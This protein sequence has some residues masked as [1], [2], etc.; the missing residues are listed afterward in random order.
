MPRMG[1]GSA[2]ALRYS[3]SDGTGA[4][5]HTR[6][7]TATYRD[8]IGV[9]Q[10]AGVNVLRDSHYARNPATGLYE[11]SALIELAGANIVLQSENFGVTWG[12]NGTPT[13]VA[14]AHTASGV[15]LDLITDDDGAVSEGYEQPI[16][17]TGDAV[18]AVSIFV[19]EGTIASLVIRIRDTTAAVNRL[20]GTMTWV[21]GVPSLAMT[22][23]TYLGA[24]AYADGVYRL[25]FATSTVTAA[26]THFVQ[27]FLGGAGGLTGTIYMGGVQIEN[28]PF[29]TSY[30]PTTVAVA[31][32]AVD[33]WSL[34]FTMT[35]QESTWYV[36]FIERGT[37]QISSARLFQLSQSG[38]DANAFTVRDNGAGRYYARLTDGT[39]ATLSDS[40]MAVAPLFGDLVELR[41][42]ISPAGVVQLHQSVNNGAEASGVAGSAAGFPSQWGGGTATLWLGSRGGAGAGAAEFYGVKVA[43]GTRT[44]AEMRAA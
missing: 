15:S 37:L 16:V 27:V 40:A 13:R 5:T 2:L 10:S 6:A 39:P 36:K 24:I 4:S 17:F 38:A 11:R 34:L 12:L 29:P 25:L 32:R 7:G 35:P 23:G 19:K 21:S 9:Q 8:S 26:N 30:K 31:P 33:V 3:P 18:K 44:L 14:A 22:A 1:S 43:R 41:A 20:N 42:T 28:N